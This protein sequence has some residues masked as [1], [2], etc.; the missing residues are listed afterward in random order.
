M[1]VNLTEIL[2]LAAEEKNAIGA[3]NTPNLENLHAVIHAAERLNI[4]VIIA[5]AE[6]HE[7]VAPLEES[8]PV[9]VAAAR[10]AKVPVCVHLDH[11]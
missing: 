8:G 3:F 5:H 2:Q 7:S 1:L 6:L 11:C 4:P 9:M 10:A